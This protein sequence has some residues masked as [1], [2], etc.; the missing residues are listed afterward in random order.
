MVNCSIYRAQRWWVLYDASAQ[1]VGFRV[2][3]NLDSSSSMPSSPVRLSSLNTSNLSNI[4]VEE[5]DAEQDH[6]PTQTSEVLTIPKP[7]VVRSCSSLWAE[8]SHLVL[9]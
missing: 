4:G 7:D 2:V 1:V 3:D 5:K 8:V 9:G 6:R